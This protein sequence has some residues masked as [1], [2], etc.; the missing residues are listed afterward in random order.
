V[1][2]DVVFSVWKDVVFHHPSCVD[3]IVW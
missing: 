3:V 2:C 1:V